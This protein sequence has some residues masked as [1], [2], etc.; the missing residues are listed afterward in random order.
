MRILTKILQE[1]VG[2]FVDDGTLAATIVIWIAFCGLLLR[3][4]PMGSWQGP[5][6]FLGLAGILIENARRGAR[7]RSG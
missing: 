3:L 2:L 7:S 6:L 5:I 4:L 1:L